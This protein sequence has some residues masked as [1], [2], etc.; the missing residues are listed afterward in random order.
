MSHNITRWCPE[1]GDWDDDV[2]HPAESCET[3]IKE[4]KFETRDQILKRAEQAE[5][6]RDAAVNDLEA[7][8]MK[9]AYARLKELQ[10]AEAELAALKQSILDLSHPNMRMLLAERDQAVELALDVAQCGIS[11]NAM[12]YVEV[13][14]DHDTWGEL[15]ALAEKEKP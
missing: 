15:R 13:Q 7:G 1:H 10:N 3:C 4:G 9:G 11:Y 6:E 12:K 14:I 8:F 5:A 2:D